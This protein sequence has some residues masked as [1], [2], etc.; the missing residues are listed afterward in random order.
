MFMR[1]KG[2]TERPGG[3]RGDRRRATRHSAGW[4]SR[5][6]VAN[7]KGHWYLAGA[8]YAPCMLQDLSLTGAKLELDRENGEEVAVGDRVVLDLPLGAGGGATIKLTGEVRHAAPAEAGQITAGIEF[9]EVGDLERALLLR[10][11]RDLP[12]KTRQ[13]A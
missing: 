8:E 2:D 11:L 13:S 6:V 4:A 10:L 7:G 3:P 1:R 5:Y 12:T 9:L